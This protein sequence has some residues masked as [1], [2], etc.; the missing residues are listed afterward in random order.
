MSRDVAFF[1]LVTQA[2]T[3]FI[4]LPSNNNIVTL[5]AVPTVSSTPLRLTVRTKSPKGPKGIPLGDA[6]GR[7]V[8][9]ANTVQRRREIAIDNGSKDC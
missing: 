7:R 2:L 8:S 3:V 6:F 5:S 4:S 9:H 1:V